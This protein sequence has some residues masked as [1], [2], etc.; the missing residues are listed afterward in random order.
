MYEYV[1]CLRYNTNY[2]FNMNNVDRISAAAIPEGYHGTYVCLCM[3]GMQSS[4]LTSFK[5]QI[6]LLDLRKYL[7]GVLLT[8]ISYM[9]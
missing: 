9:L 3:Y 6:N 1:C 2:D 5:R 8:L 4:S 7:K